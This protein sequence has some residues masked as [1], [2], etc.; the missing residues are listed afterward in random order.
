MGRRLG[1]EG[2]ECRQ[3][4]AASIAGVASSTP[5]N[6]I[7]D[8][9][10][11]TPQLAANAYQY[12]PPGSPWQF[13]GAAGIG[14]NASAMTG[15]NPSAPDGTQVAFL[16]GTG[17]MS[18]TVSVSAGNY[19][20]SFYA[21]QRAGGNNAQN[22]VIQVLVDG[23]QVGSFTPAN[24]QYTL[25]QTPNFPLTDGAHTVELAGLDPLGSTDTAFVDEV[26]MPQG[27][28]IADD[29]FELPALTADTFAYAPNGVSAWQFSP[30]AGVAAN[31]SS[32]TVN[33]PYAPDG[34]QVALL[35]GI[36]NIS[37]TVYLDG[38]YNISFLAAQRN[39]VNTAPQE[40]Q[41]LLD[42]SPLGTAT[43]NGI[44]YRAYQ[45][46]S[47][48]VAAGTH[49][50]E[51]AGLT[52]GDNT[53]FIDEVLIAPAADAIGDGSFEAPGLAAGTYQSAP[54][55]SPWQFSGSAGVSTNGSGFT[56]Y[57]PNAPNGHQV[58][59][60]QGSGSMSQSVYL[61][62]GTYSISFE[63]AQR[64]GS[65]NT[66]NQQIQ[67]LVGSGAAGSVTPV[68][69]N[70]EGTATPGGGVYRL[71]QSD[72]FTVTS[73]TYTIELAGLD[74]GKNT[75]LVDEVA[76]SPVADMISDSSFAAPGLAS[77]TYQA[78]PDG[79]PWQF[80]G[81]A[82][83][84]ANGSTMTASNPYAP[85]GTQVAYLRGAGSMSQSV[86]L[87][88]GSYSISFLAAQQAGG[89][90][91]HPQEIQVFFGSTP[92]GSGTPANLSL[93]G[94][95]T[96]TS[97]QY[98]WCQTP[99]FLVAAAGMYTIE[100]A[101]LSP[102]GE[103]D[104]ALVDEV[105]VPAGDAISDGS[106]EAPT[107][108]AST[109]AYAPG[110]S[111]WR[112]SGAAGL[113][114]NGSALVAG[115]PSAPDGSQVAF[116]QGNGS[117]SQTVQLGAGSYSI[118]FQAMQSTAS[119]QAGYLEIQVLLDGSQV[120]LITPST[121]Q[122]GSY[123][124]PD[125]TAK[126]GTHTI[127]F[128]ALNPLGGQNTAFIDAVTMPE[129]N[130]INDDSFEVPQVPMNTFRYA[131]NGSAWQF[132]GSAGVTSDE[133]AFTNSNPNAPDGTQSAF[134]QG[135]GSISQSVYLFG[136]TYSLAF[137]AAQRADASQAHAQEIEVLVDGNAVGWV[138]PVGIGYRSYETPGFT[139][140]PGTHTIE[141]AGV[142]PSGGDCT[143][144]VDVATL[145]PE[146]NAIS[147]GSF[148]APGL[149]AQSYQA[150][151]NGSP[152]QFSGTAG[153]SGNNTAFTSANPN[154]PNGSQVA[155][156]QGTGSVN[157]I[158]YLDAGSYS[159]SYLAAQRANSYQ[160]H[161]QQ[162][163][164]L[165]G[166]IPAGASTAPNMTVVGTATPVGG[167]Y[168]LCQ[169]ANFTVPAGAYSI[170]LAGMNAGKGS[171]ALIDQV[172]IAPVVDA[173]SDGSF[174]AM[175]LAAN[176]YQYRPDG[177][178]WQFGGSAGVSGNGS[179]FTASNPSAPDGSQV[180][181]LQGTGS[182]SQSVYL[183]AGTYNL[184]FLAAQRG[185]SS[186]KDSQGIEVLLGSTPPGSSTPGNL[187]PL[188]SFTPTSTLYTSCQ[189]SFTITTAGTY[190]IEFL[191]LDL[192]GKDSTA[193][194]D[195]VQI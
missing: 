63:A 70:P 86:Y 193:L 162:I 111:P 77:D 163:E 165:V 124:T 115:V 80:S 161:P 49:T 142:A 35:Q 88:P 51:L 29:S 62:A 127:Q 182:I 192:S 20:I 172:A 91:K 41:V 138:T 68:S 31:G 171:T 71:Y 75:A 137:D 158:I 191:G 26:A 82:G 121:A 146:A 46:P 194:L 47:F 53:A 114:G 96:P 156:L 170:E 106:F 89:V 61:D 178:P 98:G 56:S 54:D 28:L 112:F 76:V 8:G 179:A 123:Q 44:A 159:I 139:V 108:A 16:Q 109:F 79:S 167:T 189:T 174:E 99:S 19:S 10:F 188:V 39:G 94:S 7:N 74:S 160:T 190:T 37:Q 102:Q 48:T 33:N 110:D 73:G 186:Q 23:N 132:T 81:T 52:S 195:S 185:G 21:A 120:G 181:F 2:L 149:P 93:I 144:F 30:A 147:D 90:N 58:A 72:N 17:N 42:G 122:Y 83:V 129:G 133:S 143:A 43:P 6:A 15:N 57:N 45:T 157:Q 151:P 59:F 152:W 55:G 134:L 169:T 9:S 150:D 105:S 183:D 60:L 126:A 100:L 164:V 64:A 50:I 32:F 175:G 128:V 140:L 12:A 103:S 5:L 141:L 125:F 95:A 153:V 136:G 38:T 11:E 148:E 154:A 65:Y 13:S 145:T 18:Q 97:G 22:Q 117:V 85:D 184:S 107:L 101:G 166:S 4:L 14:R 187:S 25:Y 40:I 113:A 34:T 119:A 67:I 168:R 177:S 104:T 92:S 118:S 135:K 116:L 1:F 27:N 66:Q 131:P 180:A 69:M 130:M 84:A 176:T 173:I 3:L 24:G 155:Y 87:D 78:T 36:S